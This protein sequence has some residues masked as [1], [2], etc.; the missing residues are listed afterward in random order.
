MACEPPPKK[1][2]NRKTPIRCW[3]RV[4]V[5]LTAS[6]GPQLPPSTLGVPVGPPGQ[7]V[8]LESGR[9]AHGDSY[10]LALAEEFGWPAAGH[11]P[12]P[13]STPQGFV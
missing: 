1:H 6:L 8:L 7:V 10:V 4:G 2:E 5:P 3:V 12:P 13:P 11:E 9:Y